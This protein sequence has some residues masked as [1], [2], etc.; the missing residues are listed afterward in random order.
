MGTMGQNLGFQ[1]LVVYRCKVEG[2]N[3]HRW[4][5]VGIGGHQRRWENASKKIHFRKLFFEFRSHFRIFFEISKT[6]KLGTITFFYGKNF[7]S[8]AQSLRKLEQKLIFQNLFLNQ[9]SLYV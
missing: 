9:V 4:Y 1:P 6:K 2:P 8:L 3:I 7:R 5:L